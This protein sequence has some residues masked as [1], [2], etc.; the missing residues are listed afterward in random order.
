MRATL[1]SAVNFFVSIDVSGRRYGAAAILLLAAF[2]MASPSNATAEVGAI[3]GN[4]SVTP[5]GGVDYSIPLMAPGGI[6]GLAPRLALVYGSAIG[7]GPV[8]WGTTVAGM[9]QITRCP[10]TYA[11][12]GSS[13]PVNLTSRD[14]FC[15]D[16]QELS[17]VS[18]TYGADGTTYST[19]PTAHLEA[20][21]HTSN[22]AAG[23]DWFAVLHPD[24]TIYEYGHQ[25]SSE[26]TAQNFSGTTVG[27]AWHLDQ[28][29]DPNGNT[30][31]F[32]YSLD[33][34]N[35]VAYLSSVDWTGNSGL[36]VNPDHSLVFAYE[37][38]P[39]DAYIRRYEGGD[40]V[41]WLQRLKTVTYEYGGTTEMTYTLSYLADGQGSNHSRLSSVTECDSNGNCLPATS[42]TWQQGSRGLGSPSDTGQSGPSNDDYFV[43]DVNGD[44][45]EDLI[46]DCGGDWCIRLGQQGG[47]FGGWISSGFAVL[48]PG[49]AQPIHYEPGAGD[50]I[51]VENSSTHDWEI[52]KYDGSWSDTDTGIAVSGPV[53]AS[54][55]N[56]D[57][58][59]DLVTYVNGATVG[60]LVAYLNT[61]LSMGSLGFGS[62][63]TVYT[64]DNSETF[65]GFR[66]IGNAAA[67]GPHRAMNFTGLSDGIVARMHHYEEICLNQGC[68]QYKIIEYWHD[69]AFV[70]ENGGL[71]EYGGFAHNTTG[72]SGGDVVPVD[73]NGDGLT[74][75]VVTG[76]SSLS[77]EVNTGLGFDQVS[78]SIT[79]TDYP[80]YASFVV[81]DVTGDGKDDVLVRGQ[82]GYWQLF[83][84]TGTQLWDAG[85]TTTANGAFGSVPEVVDS[86]GV[87]LYDLVG[88][89]GSSHIEFAARNGPYPDLVTKIDD[90]IGNYYQPSWTPLSDDG[91]VTVTQSSGRHLE[92]QRAGRYIVSSVVRNDGTGGNYTTSYSYDSPERFA[93]P[94]P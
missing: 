14:M 57:G 42:L 79:S 29:S 48:N 78:T 15:L 3:G 47:G 90:G 7:G 17:V 43:A 16:G 18:G 25:Y 34:T 61:E 62:A 71:V 66:G 21:S 20:I 5:N 8:G 6:R 9:S 41:A 74:D 52:L 11:I 27:I 36:G 10:S 26:V 24:G 32:H 39:A 44:G 72:A 1:R 88:V 55:I 2:C 60:S 50:D 30:I 81:D 68:T 80:D 64:N 75:L 67:R 83:M 69:E 23:P 59:D 35:H 77:L 40:L 53:V 82:D 49:Y 73:L 45:R 92:I 46:Y 37:S 63:Q 51:L 33:Q 93:S 91:V 84:S 58:Y 31:S 76:S 56:G 12:D 38:A 86:G 89:N 94:G 70:W 65:V 22:T 87:G 28:I 54:D 4:F 13:A 85:D 19:T